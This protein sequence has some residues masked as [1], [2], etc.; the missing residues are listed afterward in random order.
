M[1]LRKTTFHRPTAFATS[2]SLTKLMLPSPPRVIVAVNGTRSPAAL[3]G[4][5]VATTLVVF[6]RA[7]IC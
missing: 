6:S 4:P 2:T 3:S 7:S 5:G 1:A